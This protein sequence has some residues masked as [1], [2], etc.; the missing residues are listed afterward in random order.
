MIGN[1][2]TNGKPARR[3]VSSGRRVHFDLYVGGFVFIV[4]V[5]FNPWVFNL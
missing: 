1:P 5:S 2:I 3:Q 4:P